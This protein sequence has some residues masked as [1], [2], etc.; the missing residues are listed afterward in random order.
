MLQ[1]KALF[2][3]RSNSQDNHLG[4]MLDKSSIKRKYK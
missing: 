3:G 4:L 2:E 1:E